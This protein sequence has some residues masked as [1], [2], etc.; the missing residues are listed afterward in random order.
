[1]Q[2]TAGNAAGEIRVPKLYH[3]RV[4]FV[5][6]P[7]R[8]RRVKSCIE[9]EPIISIDEKSRQTLASTVPKI[10]L[11]KSGSRLHAIAVREHRDEVARRSGTIAL[12]TSPSPRSRTMTAMRTAR[13]RS[14]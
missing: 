9:S 12:T 4:R 10:A 3:Q 1:M 11:T 7:C 2:R 13:R 8:A 5:C 6:Q 14:D